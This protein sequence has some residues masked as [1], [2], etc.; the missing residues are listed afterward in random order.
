MLML[1]IALGNLFVPLLLTA[2]SKIKNTDSGLASALLNVGQQIGGALG[3]SVMATVFGTAARNY[4]GNHGE[5]LF[6][7]INTLPASLQQPVSDALNHAGKNGLQPEQIQAFV[8][9]QPAQNR[10]AAEAFFS[11]SY[12]NFSHDLIAHAS[13]Q[14]FLAGAIFGIISVIA[15]AVLINVKKTEVATDPMEVA[16]AAA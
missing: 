10:P 7:K 6:S 5:T 11:G 14:A 8:A 1:A 12:S 4:F 9:Q 15:A 2:V 16:A 3:L 13:G